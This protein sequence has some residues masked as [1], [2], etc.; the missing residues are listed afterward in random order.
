MRLKW[1]V[2]L[3]I[4]LMMAGAVQAQKPKGLDIYFIDVEGGAA[5]LIVTPARESVL[6]DCGIPGPRDSGRILKAAQLAGVKAIDHLIITHWHSDHFGGVA[7]LKRLIPIRH[8]YDRGKPKPDYADERDYS[9][10]LL[11]SYAAATKGKS[12]TLH[13]GD[14]IR[15]KSVGK[16]PVEL[17]TVCGSGQFLPDGPGAPP[18]PLASEVTMKDPDPSDNAQSLGFR[19]QFGDFTFLDLGDLTWNME[20]KLVTP[21]DKIGA[22]EVFQTT[23]HGLE[24]SNNAVLIK[25]IRPRVA[26]FNNGPKKGGH[27][28]VTATLRSS[29]DIK[30]IFQ[31]HKNVGASDEQ[32]AP[33][34]RIANIDEKCAGEPI[35]LFVE[36]DSRSYTVTVG[37]SGMPERFETRRGNQARA[38]VR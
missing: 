9:K 35:R 2:P 1:I 33:A 32:N 22:I 7:D 38:S 27:P 26:V 8:F 34:S 15:L 5:T 14:H 10:K 16:M 23:H 4:C 30:A 29:P 25:T 11:A 21:T 6:I 31:L 20:S 28:E 18:N 19:L 24:I 12:T 36:P 37:S 13:A 3:V 17:L